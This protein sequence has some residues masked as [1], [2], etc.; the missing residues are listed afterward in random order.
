VMRITGLRRV[1]R[2]PCAALGDAFREGSDVWPRL[3]V[4][5]ERGRARW[6]YRADFCF[7]DVQ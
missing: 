6:Q 7:L 4:W 5:P 2:D 1:I 3:A